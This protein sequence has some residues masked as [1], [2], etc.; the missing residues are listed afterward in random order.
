VYPDSRHRAPC[1][2]PGALALGAIGQ[3]LLQKALPEPLRPIRV[4][5]RKL[6]EGQLR[7]GHLSNLLSMIE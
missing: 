3:R 5:G 1:L 6:D 7:T 4:V 2:T